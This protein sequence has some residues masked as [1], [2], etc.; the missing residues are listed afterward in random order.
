MDNRVKKH[1]VISIEAIL[2]FLVGLFSSFFVKVIGATTI[3]ELFLLLL[4]LYL[5]ITKKT[6]RIY[7][8][9]DIKWYTWFLLLSAFSCIMSSIILDYGFGKTLKNI[10]IIVVLIPGLYVLYWLLISNPYKVIYYLIGVIISDLLVRFYFPQFSDL[11]V[12]ERGMTIDERDENLFYYTYAPYFTLIV[13]L[14]YMK[15]SRLTIASMVVIGFIF[16]YGGSRANFLIYLFSA[17]ILMFIGT[18]KSSSYIRTNIRK[19]KLIFVVIIVIAGLG[20]NET[21]T[22]FAS[23]GMLGED[24]K[25]KYE[26]QSLS[27][28]GNLGGRSS[29]FRGLIAVAHHPIIGV[30]DPTNADIDDNQEILEDYISFVDNDNGYVLRNDKNISGHSTIIDWWLSYGILALPFWVFVLIQCYVCLTKYFFECRTLT[31]YLLV[32]VLSLLWDIFF[33]P[34][35]FRIRYEIVI[36]LMAVVKQYGKINYGIYKF[37]RIKNVNI[38]SV[39][40]VKYIKAKY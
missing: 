36:A 8:N 13:A 32:G 11:I 37:K 24:A 12:N 31:A 25:N 35:G 29:F 10:L 14:F 20:I 1:S 3:S 18:K 39:N 9:K 28:V 30:M 17:V 22:Y 7:A 34:F 33:S 27:N 15:F 4:F 40:G 16:L 23:T 21:Y 5:F 19:Y 26:M 6:L 2:L 38:S